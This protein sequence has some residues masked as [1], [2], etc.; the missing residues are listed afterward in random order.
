MK[1]KLDQ[2][3]PTGNPGD[4]NFAASVGQMRK[5]YRKCPAL[6]CREDVCGCAL[7]GRQEGNGKWHSTDAE[8]WC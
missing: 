2:L 3:S 6:C 5:L 8:A 7:P 4:Y 1:L